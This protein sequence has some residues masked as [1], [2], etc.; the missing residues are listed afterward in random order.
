VPRINPS[1]DQLSFR[2]LF[3]LLLRKS[4]GDRSYLGTPVLVEY[5]SGHSCV[6]VGAQSFE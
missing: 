1:Q 2:D 4:P 6:E 3:F 5:I